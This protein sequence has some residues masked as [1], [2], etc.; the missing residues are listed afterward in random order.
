MRDAIALG[1][2]VAIARAMRVPW[3]EI[4][5]AEQ[6]AER[7]LRHFMRRWRADLEREQEPN[8]VLMRICRM[9]VDEL[10]AQ[11]ERMKRS[12]R[13]RRRRQPQRRTPARS[14]RG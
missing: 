4:A 8:A 13:A 12:N 6:V 14:S 11:V 7:T 1:Q 9:R 3:R 5:E 2:R 10:A